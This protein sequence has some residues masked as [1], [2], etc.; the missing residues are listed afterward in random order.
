MAKFERD[1]SGAIKDVRNEKFY[2]LF[3]GRDYNNNDGIKIEASDKQ[4]TIAVY[5]RNKCTSTI[6]L[7]LEDC[8]VI[9]W[10]N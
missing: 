3:L 7:P 1:Y 9:D 8:N 10:V 6:V 5:S 4:I 2:R